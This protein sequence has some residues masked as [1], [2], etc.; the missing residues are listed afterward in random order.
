MTKRKNMTKGERQDA[1]EKSVNQLQTATRLTQMLMQQTGQSLQNI[2]RDISEL[3]NRQREMQ[4]RLRAYQDIS[5]IALSD[6]DKKSTELQITDFDEF[7][8][9][10]DEDNNLIVTDTVEEDSIVIFTTVAP[11]NKGYLR[12]KQ[13][14]EDI[15]FPQMRED[16]LGKKVGATIE[17]DI[18]GVTHS[19][20]LLGVRKKEG[21]DEQ[22][23]DTTTEETQAAASV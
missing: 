17:V 8:A 15:G 19:L 13:A 4:Y 11:D 14:L 9:K 16:L 3:A 23:D 22:L 2:Q 18:N 21:G 10:D 1:L 20:T 6:V 5:G 7:S 12:S